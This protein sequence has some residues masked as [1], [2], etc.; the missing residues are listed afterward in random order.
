MVYFLTADVGADPIMLD[1]LGLKRNQLEGIID[2]GGPAVE[3]IEVPEGHIRRL[4]E[5]YLA[6]RGLI[7][8]TV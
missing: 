1:T 2:P 8:K 3:A 4:A 7:P 6:R 5:E